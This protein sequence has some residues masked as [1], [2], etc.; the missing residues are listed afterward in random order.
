MRAPDQAAELVIAQAK[1][2]DTEHPGDVLERKHPFGAP[3]RGVIE[4]DGVRRRFVLTIGHRYLVTAP[5]SL[6]RWGLVLHRSSRQIFKGTLPKGLTIQLVS[7]PVPIG[8]AAR[9]WPRMLSKVKQFTAKST[10]YF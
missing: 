2:R 7:A 3:A 9:V 10:L 5:R 6:E 1:L 8:P 4:P